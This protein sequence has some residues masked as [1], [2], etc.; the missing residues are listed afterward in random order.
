MFTDIRTPE[1]LAA[2]IRAALE[3]A[4]RYGGRETAHHKAWVIDQMCRALAGD[5]YAEY[6]AGV[7]AGEDGPDTYAWDEGIAP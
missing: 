6:V 5:G 7:C 1:E 3:T 4:A 2:A